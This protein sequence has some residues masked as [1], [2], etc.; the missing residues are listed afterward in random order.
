MKKTRPGAYTE[1]PKTH[2][3][4]E[5]NHDMSK[6]FKSRGII[7]T[8][9]TPTEA[10]QD[11]LDFKINPAMRKLPSYLK[12]PKHFIQK[13]T[14]L[15]ESGKIAE[16]TNVVSA[17]LENMYGNMPLEVSKTGVKNFLKEGKIEKDEP[18]P[19]EVME[20]LDLCQQNNIFEFNGQL[21]KQTKGHGT[22][23][24]MAPPVACSGAGVIEKQFLSLPEVSNLLDEENWWRYIDDVFSITEG[25]KEDIDRALSLFN[26]LYPGQ[27]TLTWEWSDKSMIFLNVELFINREKRILETKYYVKPSNQQLFLNYRSNHP[28]HI[29]KGV[30]YG[31]ALQGLMINSRKEWNLEYLLELREKFLQQEYPVDLINQQFTRAL[32]VD[33]ADLLLSDPATRKKRRMIVAPLIVTFSPA[34]PPYKR[35]ISEEISILHKD[36]EMKKTFPFINVVSRQNKNIRRR[37]MRNRFREDDGLDEQQPVP[38]L[39]SGNFKFHNSRCMCCLRLEDGKTKYSA[40]KTKRQYSIKRHYTCQTTF[41]VYVVTC[42]L[43]SAQYTG[44]TTKTMRERHYGHRSEVKRQ[45]DGVGAHFFHHAEELGINLDTN[46]EDIMQYFNLTIIASVEPDMP[47]SR[48]RLDT[49]EADMMERMMTM[50]SYGGINL[51]VERRRG[52]GGN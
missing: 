29:F 4:D 49:L 11:W 50:E 40:T 26:S 7:A 39:P 35:W 34:N 38:S 46:M 10:L 30:V 25:N 5:I 18:K 42:G 23:Q 48:D 28:D 14:N 45:E 27:V 21:Y 17:D 9:G 15:N 37:I 19:E 33:R 41:C 36:E 3:F 6:G 13:I 24:K 31:M 51:R 12:D 16:Q 8:N 1:Q 22:G 32:A 47:W 43:C 2:K 52:Q 20:A 44:Q